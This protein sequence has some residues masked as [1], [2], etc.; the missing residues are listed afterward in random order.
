M[1]YEVRD[2]YDKTDDEE[3][4]AIV[5]CKVLYNSSGNISS[6]SPLRQLS[7]LS[8]RSA[9]NTLSPMRIKMIYNG[10]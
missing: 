6:V 9:N 5:P 1:T 7:G 8:L 2:S 10:F 3:T 4:F